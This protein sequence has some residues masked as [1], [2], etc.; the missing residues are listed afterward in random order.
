M[1]DPAS[2][3]SVPPQPPS[4]AEDAATLPVGSEQ[5]RTRAYLPPSPAGLD[6]AAG[7][8]RELPVKLG[9]YELRK[10]LGKGGMGAVYLAHD[11]E[12]DRP[13]ALKVPSFAG[14]NATAMDRFVQEARAAATLAHPNLCPVY[15]AGTIDGIRYLTMAYVEGKSLATLLRN[16]RP[17]PERMAA[18][19]VRQLALAMQAAHDRGIIHRDLKPENIMI[20][21]KKQPVIMDFGLARRVVTPRAARLTQQ[22]HVLGTPAY[23]PPEQV[24]G[25]LNAMGPGSDI[26]SLGVILYLLLTGRLPFDPAAGLGSLLAQIVCDAPPSPR[27]FRPD[28]SPALEAICLKTLAKRPEERP[29]SM[30]ALAKEL[31]GFLRKGGPAAGAED[32]DPTK[33]VFAQMVQSDSDLSP[34]S[35]TAPPAGRTG[36]RWAALVGIGS[37]ALV[38]VAVLVI[39]LRRPAEGTASIELSYPDATVEV[40]V[41]GRRL[42]RSELGQPLPLAPGEHEVTV[43]GEGFET[44]IEPFTV[45]KDRPTHVP[46]ALKRRPPVSPRGSASASQ[47][48]TVP[49][50]EDVA[51]PTLD[52]VGPPEPNGTT[53]TRPPPPPPPLPTGP[54]PVPPE[55]DVQKARAQIRQAHAQPY[56]RQD[57]LTWIKLAERLRGQAEGTKNDPAGRYALWQEARQ[58]A[59]QAADPGLA[60]RISD[61]L[62]GAFRV[63]G[64]AL[65]ATALRGVNDQL[66]TPGPALPAADLPLFNHQLAVRCLDMLDRAVAARGFDTALDALDIAALAEG[67]AR[68]GDVPLVKARPADL[69]TLRPAFARLQKNPEDAAA[70]LQVGRFLCLSEGRWSVG[71]PLLTRASDS[72][73]QAAARR[74]LD[75]SADAA[76]HV[77][78]GDAWRLVFDRER[79]RDRSR[80]GER[81][82][83][84]YELALAEL[85]P[86]QRGPVAAR[87]LHVSVVPNLHLRQPFFDADAASDKRPFPVHKPEKSFPVDESYTGSRWFM[88]TDGG[89]W[90]IGDLTRYAAPCACELVARVVDPPAAAWDLVLIP[91]KSMIHYIIRV[92][93]TATVQVL[94]ED[95]RTKIERLLAVSKVRSVKPRPGFHTLLAVVRARQLD[96]YLDGAP[97]QTAPVRLPDSIASGNVHLGI[98]TGS[99]GGGQ[100]EVKRLTIWSAEGVPAL[101]V[102]P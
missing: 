69:Q 53:T 9:R 73:W 100:V 14:S 76:G 79:G 4:A 30:T 12:L 99:A 23:M 24:N 35:R 21:P 55:A 58:L 68:D 11:T 40:R 38:L 88:R 98:Y 87:A 75:H 39:V 36:F 89:N 26:Y 92:D 41:D 5:G 61:D 28:L 67:R 65:K 66:A 78:V 80:L 72:L 7:I 48:G 32:Q 71:L 54:L 59:I 33:L 85:G 22:G 6:L 82:R 84:W 95:D 83:G 60:L 17:L 97:V 74:E 70:N 101:G 46:V 57:R 51:K 13:V 1:S 63:D 64:L 93:G 29:A 62:A 20:T 8:S 52:F 37:A 27:A 10:L 45:H 81:A 91:Q 16:G 90:Y 47:E 19:L 42:E 102:R 44:V 96:V 34:R 86:Q 94:V 25:D 2:E 3:S 56:A 77:A 15:D 18:V 49:K 43:Q 31:E 50:Q